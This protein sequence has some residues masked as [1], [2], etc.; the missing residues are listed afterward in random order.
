MSGT[1]EVRD[2]TVLFAGA[3]PSRN[4]DDVRTRL[5]DPET[6]VRLR[7]L[8]GFRLGLPHVAFR[9][10]SGAC[11]AVLGT[12]GSGK[13]SL[14][15]TLAG[16]QPHARGQV[17]VN[18]RDVSSLPAEMRGIVYLHQEPVLFPHLSVLEN[19]AFPLIIRGV[20]RADATRRAWD[21]IGRLGVMEVGRNAATALSGGQRHRVALARA[22]CADP[23]VLLLDEPLSSLD[24]AVR[25]DVRTALLEARAISGAATVL[26]THDLDD[27]M[28]VATHITTIDERGAL[29][30]PLSSRAILD[31][32]PS[33]SAARL[34]GVF[35]EVSGQVHDG[36]FRWI[37]GVID[38]PGVT[39][40][41]AVACCRAHAV[42]LSPAP[43]HAANTLTL[44]A[45]R[46]GAH[47]T[48]LE[49]C[50]ALGAVV[51]LRVPSNATVQVG[52]RVAVTLQRAT[53]FAQD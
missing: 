38:A 41:P 46:E 51:S 43:T 12:S 28:A 32:P 33:L 37:G 29:T 18:D 45:R 44:T 21:V 22:L 39:D 52:D 42:A 11:L 3:Q 30:D 13:S 2:L 4:H 8:P 25:R 35:A 17:L 20:S 47:D 40:G 24:P 19:V 31:A 15:R 1:L 10:P 6:A 53:I 48:V 16:L 23:A 7:G 5:P 49:L 50:D 27:A 9:V 36:Q 26:V 34:L 14:L